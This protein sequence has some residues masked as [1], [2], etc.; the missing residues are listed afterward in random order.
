MEPIKNFNVE[1]YTGTWYEIAR[2]ENSFEKGLEKVFA[3]Y[4]LRKD[5]YGVNV[6][7]KGYNPER[8]KWQ[9]I[10]GKAF[11]RDSTDVGALRVSF[12]WPFYSSYNIVY[13]DEDYQEAIACGGSKSFM[14]ILSRNEM[15]QEQKLEYLVNKAE[16]LGFNTSQLKFTQHY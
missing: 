14:W 10:S 9:T 2:L 6:L 3:E 5:G 15:L 1:K 12:F 16:E 13:L 7:N 8:D 4:T 11:F